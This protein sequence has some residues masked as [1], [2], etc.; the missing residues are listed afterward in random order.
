MQYIYDIKYG[1]LQVRKN[2]I[3]LRKCSRGSAYLRTLE[4]REHWSPGS[5][6]DL[7]AKA[8][9]LNRKLGYFFL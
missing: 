4:R 2:E 6:Y 1:K 9:N 5:R 8:V 3:S 7:I